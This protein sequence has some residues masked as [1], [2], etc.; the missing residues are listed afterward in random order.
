M[1][2]ESLEFIEPAEL[3]AKMD[4]G[5]AV[6]VVDARNPDEFAARHIPGARNVPVADMPQGLEQIAAAKPNLVVTTCGSSGRGEK[7]ARVMAQNG[8]AHVA[9]LRGGLAAWR[10]AGYDAIDGADK[11]NE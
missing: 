7:A 5:A 4:G 6:L 10:N 8:F 1:T 11:Q 9:V 3:K 2:D